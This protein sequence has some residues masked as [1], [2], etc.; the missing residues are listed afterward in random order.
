M[1]E[2]GELVGRRKNG[3]EFPVEVT[4]SKVDVSGQVV[5]T[6]IAR[7]ITE[8]RRLEDQLKSDSEAKEAGRGRYE[9]YDEA[10]RTRIR[11]LIALES[12]LRSNG[13]EPP[14]RASDGQQ[15]LSQAGNR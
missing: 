12:D 14:P 1:Q 4:I 11:D 6:A 15:G 7:D 5:L 13:P 8:R 3:A 10:L 9:I 2:R